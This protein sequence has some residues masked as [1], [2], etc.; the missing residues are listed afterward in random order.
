MLERNT[1]Q[2]QTV[3]RLLDAGAAELAEVGPDKVT[4]RTVA[5]RAGVSSATAY[6]YFDSKDHLFAE[7]F[8]RHLERHPAPETDGDATARLQAVL[9]A[10]S[11]DLAGAPALAAAATRALLGSDPA[12][13]RVRT[14]IGAEYAARLQRALGRRRDAQLLL[15]TLL[16]T[17]LGTM[18]QAGMGALTYTEMGERL[19]SAV[20]VILRG[21]R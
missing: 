17:V 14:R 11:D 1:R 10:M 18:L 21:H 6:T 16:S 3:D 20:A 9:R 13:A 12:V 8:L 4:V 2:Q 7:L 5:A 19:E 15:D